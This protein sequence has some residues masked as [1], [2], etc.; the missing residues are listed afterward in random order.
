[1]VLTSASTI[2]ISIRKINTYI[3]RGHNDRS[4]ALF[5]DEL[6]QE[7]PDTDWFEPV[8][9]CPLVSGVSNYI[10]A[11]SFIPI[12]NVLTR[13]E[14][15]IAKN[16][17]TTYDYMVAIRDNLSGEDLTSASIS[18]ENIT[19]ENFSWEEFDFTG[20][21]VIPGITYYIVSYTVNATDNWYAWGSEN[22]YYLSWNNLLLN[23]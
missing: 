16:S 8:G 3:N 6:D 2:E 9:P 4:A 17:T 7:Q 14:L 12:K 22:E 18:A 23:R 1:L 21:I 20:I 5:F 11:Q 19:T 10:I 15:M 13:V